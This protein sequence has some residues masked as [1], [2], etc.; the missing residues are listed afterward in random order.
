[1]KLISDLISALNTSGSKAGAWFW[2]AVLALCSAIP[3]VLF[4]V[5][6]T[7]LVLTHTGQM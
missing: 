2:G 4:T 5:V 7:A 1:M 3:F 6:W